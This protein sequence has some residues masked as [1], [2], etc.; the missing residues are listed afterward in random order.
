MRV[1]LAHQRDVAAERARTTVGPVSFFRFRDSGRDRDTFETD[2][3][4]A[5]A[6]SK[7]NGEKEFLLINHMEYRT[8]DG[9]YYVVC[10]IVSRP[11]PRKILS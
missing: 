1:A 11:P 7:G 10:N 5:L 4:I 8:N 9:T 3:I 2:V 6:A